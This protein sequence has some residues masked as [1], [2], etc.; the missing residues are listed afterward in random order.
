MSTPAGDI[1]GSVEQTW[2]IFKPHFKITT[3][4][5][6]TALRIKG[7]LCPSWELCWD[8]VFQV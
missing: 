3:A 7:P 4:G 6:D 2:S 8:R 1:L 5:G